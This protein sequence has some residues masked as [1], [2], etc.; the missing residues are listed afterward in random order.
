MDNK[1]KQLKDFVEK[2]IE[3]YED[4]LSS[5]SDIYKDSD[6]GSVEALKSVL[7]KISSLE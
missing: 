1:I 3:L 6:E 7:R 2:Q 5:K 4:Y